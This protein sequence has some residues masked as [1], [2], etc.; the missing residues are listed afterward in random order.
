MK[1]SQIIPKSKQK[2]KEFIKKNKKFKK[3]NFYFKKGAIMILGSSFEFEKS[4]NP[5]IVERPTDNVEMP[6][7]SKFHKN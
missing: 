6:Q 5:D 7:V 3:F 4:S 2:L 1:T